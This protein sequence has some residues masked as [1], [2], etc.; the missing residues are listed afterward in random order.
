MDWPQ[1]AVVNSA[2][3]SV[4]YTKCEHTRASEQLA[5]YSKVTL[6]LVRKLKRYSKC[7]RGVLLNSYYKSYIVNLT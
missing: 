2:K 3:I 7:S 5:R 6:E 1:Q 4:S